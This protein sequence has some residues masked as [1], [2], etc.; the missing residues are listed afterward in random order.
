MICSDQCSVDD[1]DVLISKKELRSKMD[2]SKTTAKTMAI[3]D[4]NPIIAN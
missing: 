4:T 2:Y 3:L 1:G